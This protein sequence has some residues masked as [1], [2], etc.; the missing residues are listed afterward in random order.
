MNSIRQAITAILVLIF[1]GLSVPMEADAGDL[2]SR[3]NRLTRRKNM[4]Y[5]PSRLVIGEENRFVIKGTPGSQAVLYVSPLDKGYVLPNGQSLQ[6]GKEHEKLNVTIP[7]K[8]V[9]EILVPLPNDAG[10]VGRQ[11]F[12]DAILLSE[13]ETEEQLS[14]DYVSIMDSTGR[15]ADRNAV[16]IFAPATEGH[17]TVMP[18][19]P[20]LNPQVFNRLTTLSEVYTDGDERKKE[21]IDDGEIDRSVDIDSNVF[22][23]RPGYTTPG[24]NR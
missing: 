13:G 19:M 11:L 2:S 24:A 17:T 5:L 1:I 7:E 9:V 8:G 15:Q 20:G 6:V 16:E 21:L 10:W 14:V 4:L 12:V 22:I 23:N 3:L 18:M